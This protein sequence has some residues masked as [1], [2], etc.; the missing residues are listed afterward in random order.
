MFEVFIGDFLG[1]TRVR[2]IAVQE[3]GRRDVF[4]QRSPFTVAMVEALEAVVENADADA[5]ER[6]LAGASL[7]VL[8]CRTRV[9]DTAKSAIEPQIDQSSVP[10]W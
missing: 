9:G 4:R 2:G 8:F 1:S 3:L 10:S 6:V 5:R 7:F